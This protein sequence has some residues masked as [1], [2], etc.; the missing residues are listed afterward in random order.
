MYVQAYHNPPTN[1]RERGDFRVYHL[2]P[3]TTLVEQLPSQWGT[4]RGDAEW[5]KTT[6]LSFLS[7]LPRGKVSS[8]TG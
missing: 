6:F 5:P 7:G 1:R 4:G 3:L 2:H 8:H